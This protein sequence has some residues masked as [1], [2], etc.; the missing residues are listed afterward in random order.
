MRM[1]KKIKKL[2]HIIR[3]DVYP[4][5]FMFSFNETDAELIKILDKYGIDHQNHPWQ[6]ESDKVHG[7]TCVF[8]SGQTLIRLPYFPETCEHYGCLSHEI[9]HGVEFLFYRLNMKLK[10]SSGE[11]YAY[12]IQYLTT[13]IYKQIN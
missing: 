3:T 2:N 1:A 6:F 9:F 5:D 11:A 10:K 7:R 13:E 4:F 12:L 8:E